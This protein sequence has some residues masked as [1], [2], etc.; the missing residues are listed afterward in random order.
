M[1]F[2]KESLILSIGFIL[3]KLFTLH[4][5]FKNIYAKRNVAKCKTNSVINYP[6]N[7][8]GFNDIYLDE[9]VN[10]GVNATIFSKYAKLIVGP[11]VFTG[12]N[13]TFITGDHPYIK[14]A[15]MKDIKKMEIKNKVDIS[16]YDQD[17]IIE[18]DVW[19]GANV[20]ILKGVH[21]GKGAICAA[22]AVII[23]DVPA[24]SIVGG[25]PAK[26]LKYKWTKEE[27]CEHELELLNS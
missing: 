10:I 15:Y 16:K 1:S 14:G 26:V 9:D 13:V 27:I 2:L 5:V 7:I 18:E 3:N 12:P 25:N 24:Y 19:I 20:I 23:H 21:I 22:G 11:K 17:I 6:Y 8:I 4:I